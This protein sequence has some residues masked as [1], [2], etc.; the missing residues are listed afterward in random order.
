MDGSR[1][2]ETDFTVNHC[3]RVCAEWKENKRRKHTAVCFINAGVHARDIYR[4]KRSKNIG[5][6][7]VCLHAGVNEICRYVPGTWS[8]VIVASFSFSTCAR[9]E[10]RRHNKE[11]DEELSQVSRRSYEG[12]KCPDLIFFAQEPRPFFF[13]SV[14]ACV[15][16]CCTFYP[17][18]PS[19]S[20]YRKIPCLAYTAFFQCAT[21]RQEEGFYE[22]MTHFRCISDGK[23]LKHRFFIYFFIY[24]YAFPPVR[25][26]F[27]FF[28]WG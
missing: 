27:F 1:G 15:C 5:I 13:F 14:R 20:I 10:T 23:V 22:R 11:V 17:P 8:E 21:T 9:P 26:S 16:R 24:F 4:S 19:A 18:P 6:C 12:A 25:I 2:S 28:S 3:D 7:F